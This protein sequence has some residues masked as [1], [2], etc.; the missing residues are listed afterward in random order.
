MAFKPTTKTTTLRRRF[1]AARLPPSRGFSDRLT[2]TAEVSQEADGKARLSITGEAENS[3]GQCTGYLREAIEKGTPEPPLTKADLSTLLDIW[4]RWHLNDMRAGCEHQRAD[5]RLKAT[6]TVCTYGITTETSQARR[7]AEEQA[8]DDLKA[9]GAA[10]VGDEVRVLLNLPWEYTGPEG[11]V[12]TGYEVKKTKRKHA[13]HVYPTEH[14]DGMLTRKCETC[15]YG[16]GSAWLYEPLPEDVL[17]FL[18][19]LPGGA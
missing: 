10:S 15:G 11:D 8:M 6:L 13:G 1:V 7:K 16:Y 4:E 19:S 12:R 2:I 18:A 3:W 17:A 14:P 9:L 5:P